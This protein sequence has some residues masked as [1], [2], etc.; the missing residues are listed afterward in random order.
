MRAVNLI[1]A[2]QRSGSAVGAGRSEGGAYAVLAVVGGIAVLAVLYGMAHHQITSRRAQI[3]SMTARSQQAQSDASRLAPYTSF[4][5]LREQRSQAVA[6]LVDSRFDWGHVVHEFG[7]VLPLD[8]SISAL[9]G[10]IGST[11]TSTV[12]SS[13]PAPAA[14]PA[15][16]TPASSTPVATAAPVTS[17]TPPGSVPT[18]TLAGCAAS[19]PA[20]AQMLER[21]RLIDGVATVA[22][23]S[24][25][26]VANS[27]SGG[28]CPASSPVFSV[29]ITFE[30]LPST[31]AAAASAKAVSNPT[32]AGPA[33]AKPTTTGTT[34]K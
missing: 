32:S 14:G 31:T 8:V 18:F 23:E 29:Q 1:P 19:Q 9:S 11:T 27:G 2:E 10:T 15:A 20:V 16:S 12:S 17:A 13:A 21:L 6:Q 4:I 24:S 34:S 28:G 22:L 33:A 26:K 30:A 3:A 5:A 7:R 25:T